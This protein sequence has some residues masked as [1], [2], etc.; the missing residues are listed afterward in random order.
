MGQ[1][2][3][4][5]TPRTWFFALSIN[6]RT[7]WPYPATTAINIKNTPAENSSRAL[8]TQGGNLGPLIGCKAIV[9]TPKNKDTAHY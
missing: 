9:R 5:E 3:T 1:T 4:N 8:L 2:S 7:R 6:R